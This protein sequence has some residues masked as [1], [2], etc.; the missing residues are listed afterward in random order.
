[1]EPP[2]FLSPL[3]AR[4]IE[5]KPGSETNYMYA[6]RGHII[7]LLYPYNKHN[8]TKNFKNDY[9]T[10]IILLYCNTQS[11]YTILY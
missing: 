7:D 4:V 6:E 9:C 11:M 10:T 2:S 5:S 1:M 3:G 8:A